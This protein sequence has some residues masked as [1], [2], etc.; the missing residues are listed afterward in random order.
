MDNNDKEL[1]LH[2][3]I[4]DQSYKAISNYIQSSKDIKLTDE[5][6]N[7]MVEKYVDKKIRA[8][9]KE[10]DEKYG[11]LSYLDWKI[12]DYIEDYIRQPYRSDKV[13]RLQTLIDRVIDDGISKYL[14]E[15]VIS[16][17]KKE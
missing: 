2:I 17:K 12:R 11:G 1:I 16:F 4:K 14:K 5:D 3:P 7:K 6:I 9:L 8:V 10:K 15:Y 13:S